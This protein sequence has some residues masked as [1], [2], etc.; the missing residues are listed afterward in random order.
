MK[1]TFFAAVSGLVMVLGLQAATTTTNNR[2]TNTQNG[3][4]TFVGTIESINVSNRTIEVTGSDAMIRTVYSRTNNTQTNN[5]KKNATQNFTNR[6]ERT[7]V[8]TGNKATRTFDAGGFCNI[9][10]DDEDE[11]KMGQRRSLT[12]LQVGQRISIDYV[13]GI[14]DRYTAKS[15]V[16]VAALKVDKDETAGDAKKNQQAKKKK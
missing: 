13:K 2:Q 10:T 14:G 11:G 12:D 16:T 6:G 9:R 8:S 3:S 15:I 4:T 5:N 1:S 7:L